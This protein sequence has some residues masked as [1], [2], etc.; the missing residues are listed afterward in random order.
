MN[1]HATQ[2]GLV[3]FDCKMIEFGL[4]SIPLHKNLISIQRHST[5]NESTT[6]HCKNQQGNRKRSDSFD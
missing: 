4:K 5:T 1:L 2:Q 3:A 6:R